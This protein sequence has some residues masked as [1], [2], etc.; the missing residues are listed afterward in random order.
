MSVIVRIVSCLLLL[1][2][3]STTAA[4]HP[5][6]LPAPAPARCAWYTPM[7]G[8]ATGQTVTVTATGP[9]CASQAL[10]AWIALE[11]GRP[12]ASTAAAEADGMPVTQGTVIAQLGRAGTVVR[13]WQAG[14]ARITDEAAGYL[15]DAFQSAGWAP[16]LPTG[17]GAQG[18][19]IDTAPHPAGAQ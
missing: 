4:G 19:S 13:V 17:P 7:T 3:C 5:A 10:I 15:A 2:A 14:S 12:W 11:S 16:Q 6:A 8:P 18:G 1:V 9:A